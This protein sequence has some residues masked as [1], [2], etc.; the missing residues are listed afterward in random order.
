MQEPIRSWAAPL[1]SCGPGL[2]LVLP[3]L[4]A[5]M[6][7]SP[8]H[9]VVL[10]VRIPLL[11][12][13]LALDAAAATLCRRHGW[14]VRR[15]LRVLASAWPLLTYALRPFSNTLELHC[16]AAALL[17]ALP[18]P[19]SPTPSARAM[20]GLGALLAFGT[21]IRFTFIIWSYSNILFIL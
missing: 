19:R 12:A 10:S 6:P 13:S 5:A 21:W 20:V 11:L 1:V 8:A 18:P 9:A 15:T 2:L 16:L 14:P 7:Q 4:G 17:L 3:L